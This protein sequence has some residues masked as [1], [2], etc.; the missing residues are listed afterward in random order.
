QL[1]LEWSEAVVSCSGDVPYTV[2]ATPCLSG[3][4]DCEVISG[5]PVE[6]FS[7]TESQIT[8]SVN[9]SVGLEYDF[10]VS[11][12][13]NTSDVYT[14]NLTATSSSGVE[15]SFNYIYNIMTLDVDAVNVTWGRYYVLGR[16]TAYRV[17]IDEQVVEIVTS[18][19]CSGEMCGYI[20]YSDSLNSCSSVAVYV[21]G[22]GTQRISLKNT[23]PVCSPEDLLFLGVDWTAMP[24]FTAD[25]QGVYS[26][27]GGNVTYNGVYV[28]S[29]ATYRT[30]KD[31]LVNGV[32]ILERRCTI[33]NMWTAPEL[34]ISN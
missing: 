26:F 29:T 27:H 7:T 34:I 23:S 4:G 20:H 33:N 31:Y 11:T 25:G 21:V 17:V 10:T 22:C 32:R 16:E 1:S 9:G 15:S 8:L 13:A 24:E 14:V 30:S 2:T 19:D 18:Q 5:S 3:S 12:C 28:G 6:T